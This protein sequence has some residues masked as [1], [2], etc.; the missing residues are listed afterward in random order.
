MREQANTSEADPYAGHTPLMRQY[1]ALRDTHPGVLLLFRLGDFYETFFEDAVKVSRLLGLTLTRR[2]SY[3]GEPIPMAG[4]PAA[5]LEQYLARLVRCGESVAVSEQMGDPNIKNSMME[6]KV[7]RIVTPGTLTDNALLSEKHDAILLALSVSK[8]KTA[9]AGLVWLTLTNGSFRAT[10]VPVTELTNTFAS[11]GPAEVLV[12]EAGKALL[13]SLGLSLP[14]TTLPPWHFDAER[15][16]AAIKE[17]FGLAC[18]EVSDLAH[19][20]QILAAANA[21]LGYVETTQCETTPFIEPLRLQTESAFIGIDAATRRN[22]EIDET[23]HGQAGPTLFG[24]LDR[25]RT[26]MGSRMLRDWLNHPVRDA[27]IAQSRH[28]AIASMLESTSALEDLQ[29]LLRE[30]PDIERTA[31]RLALRSIRPKEAAALRDAIPRLERLAKALTPF[32]SP[33]L[34]TLTPALH[35]APELNALL[36]KN[37]LEEPASLLREGDVIRSEANEELAMLRS[38]RDNAGTFLTQLEAR[39]R[40]RTGITALRVEYNR[41]SGYYIEVPRGQAERVPDDYRRRQTLKNAER[42]ITPE[43]KEYEDKALSA[44]ERARELERRLWDALLDELAPYVE[45]LLVASRSVA[46]IDTLAALTQH[47]YE[48]RWVRPALSPTSGIDVRGARHPVVEHVLEHYVPNDCRLCL[49]RRLLVITGPNMGGKSTYMRSIALIALLAYAGSFVPA[50]AATLGPIDKILT[51]IGASDDLARGRSTF[52]VEMTEA[53]AI[54]HEATDNSLVLMDEIGRGTSTYD[55]LSLAAAIAEELVVHSR[56]WT[57]FATHYFELTQLASTLPEVVNVHVSAEQTQKTVVFLHDVKDGPASRSYGIAVAK[58]AGIP[59]RI[60]HRA[61]AI[62]HRLEER[63]VEQGP[64]LDLFSGK[65]LSELE[66]PQAS[67]RDEASEAFLH[68]LTELPVDT[69]SPREALNLLYELQTQAKALK[70]R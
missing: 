60:I 9:K 40:E 51:R 28:E 41:V 13:D 61:S 3:Q 32:A 2:G 62:L 37:L 8:L 30:I 49:G 64:Q 21:L 54:L 38:L 66:A 26:S 53:A 47:A 55:G 29:T 24:V 27:C 48:A 36:V 35:V 18:L 14:L 50:E 23:L 4:I 12:D 16:E 52:M 6:R 31:G 11:I 17:R 22:L 25:C 19:E 58:L 46:S 45:A 57:L 20:T 67:L 63:A 1:F 65:E 43:L 10:A 44:K 33:L 59:A 15:G 56:A 7:V 5:T 42:F 34:Q 39:E 70:S 68:A 69:L